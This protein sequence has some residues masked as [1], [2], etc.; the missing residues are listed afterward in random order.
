QSIPDQRERRFRKTVFWKSL[1]DALDAPS[2]LS[3]G[4]RAALGASGL[5]WFW[6]FLIQDGG[7][8][9]AELFLRPEFLP[10][11]LLQVGQLLEQ[12]PPRTVGG[13]EPLHA[14]ACEDLTCVDVAPR[15]DRDH[16]HPVELTAVVTHA[17]HLAHELAVFAVEEINVVV[18][19]I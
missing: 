18:R 1:I 16:V 12:L 6:A 4:R 9:R 15:V 8:I 7:T 3:P 2:P 19:Q 10:C 11:A 13:H 17:A 14:L 5:L